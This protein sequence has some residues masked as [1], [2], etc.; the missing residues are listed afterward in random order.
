MS[1]AAS[2]HHIEKCA[3]SSSAVMPFPTSSISGSFQWPGPAYFRIAFCELIIFSTLLGDH[4]PL[5]FLMPENIGPISSVLRHKW[6]TGAAHSQGL[7]LPHS[8]RLNI[9]GRPAVFMALLMVV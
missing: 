3:R 5:F 1:G 7:F 8:Q 9:M 2:M 6:P 4:P